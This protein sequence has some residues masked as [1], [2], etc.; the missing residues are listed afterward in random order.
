MGKSGI[1]NLPESQW[2]VRSKGR[3]VVLEVRHGCD[4]QTEPILSLLSS[5][6]EANEADALDTQV[7]S[8]TDVVVER[9]EEFYDQNYV[10]ESENATSEVRCDSEPVK[11]SNNINIHSGSQEHDKVQPSDSLCLTWETQ[12]SEQN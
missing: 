12:P 11:I 1:W 4:V 8:V 7:S 5:R 2:L 3:R 9:N 6:C 10:S